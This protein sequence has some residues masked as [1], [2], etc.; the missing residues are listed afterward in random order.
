MCRNVNMC[1][2]IE[3]VYICLSPSVVVCVS[4]CVY[5]KH[6]VKSKVVHLLLGADHLIN[7]EE[8]FY[9]TNTFRTKF[10]ENFPKVRV[11]RWKLRNF[12][13]NWKVKGM[14][15]IQTNKTLTKFNKFVEKTVIIENFFCKE[16]IVVCKV[17]LLAWL[18]HNVVRQI[19]YNPE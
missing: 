4:L 14:L 5:K 12:P 19:I 3:I 8:N 16:P 13:K 18:S 2:E 15:S 9:Q 10:F 6:M 17:K 1:R 7:I 11:I